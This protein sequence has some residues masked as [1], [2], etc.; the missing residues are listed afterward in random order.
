[1][2]IPVVKELY[3]FDDTLRYSVRAGDQE[4]RRT[5]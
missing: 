5:K 2:K 4:Q 3:V 1:M